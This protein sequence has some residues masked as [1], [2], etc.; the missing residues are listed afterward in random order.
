M[1]P[2]APQPATAESGYITQP[3]PLENTYTTDT[4]LRRVVECKLEPLLMIKNLFESD[5]L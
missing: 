5:N 1:P 2:S 3:V 4:S